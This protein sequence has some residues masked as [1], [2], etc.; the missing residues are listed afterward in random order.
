MHADDDVGM[1]AL[2]ASHAFKPFFTTK[3][4]LSGTDQPATG[5]AHNIRIR[6][7]QSDVVSPPTLAK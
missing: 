3:R 1:D 7:V 5:K 4:G 6:Y 2:V